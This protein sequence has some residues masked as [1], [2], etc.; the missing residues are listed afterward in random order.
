MKMPVHP[1]TRSLKRLEWKLELIVVFG[2]CSLIYRSFSVS[3]QALSGQTDFIKCSFHYAITSLMVDTYRLESELFQ[4]KS[5]LDGRQ[6]LSDSCID[7][8]QDLGYGDEG[9]H[10]AGQW[11]AVVGLDEFALQVG[12]FEVG[13]VAVEP[14]GFVHALTPD[15]DGYLMVDGVDICGYIRPV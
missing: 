7:A 12:H 4:C 1:V 8:L 10:L 13:V 14:S 6:R 11:D 5:C 9:A 15:E 2:G 3:G